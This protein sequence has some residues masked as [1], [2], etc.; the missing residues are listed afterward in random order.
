MELD[1]EILADLSA[2]AMRRGVSDYLGELLETPCVVFTRIVAGE[3]GG[4]DIR[5]GLGVDAYDLC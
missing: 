1:L 2:R 5:D 4:C 3:V